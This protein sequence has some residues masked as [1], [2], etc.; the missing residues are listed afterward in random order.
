M[1]GGGVWTLLQNEITTM[2][3]LVAHCVQ[4][5]AFTVG[6]AAIHG[7]RAR[8]DMV[9]GVLLAL[10]LALIVAFAAVAM[11]PDLLAARLASATDPS[12]LMFEE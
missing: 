5:G 4:A 9:T 3:T 7:Q 8:P 11:P 1:K 6:C 10:V 12:F 2:S